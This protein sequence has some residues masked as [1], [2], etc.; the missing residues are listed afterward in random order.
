LQQL[1]NIVKSSKTTFQFF[2]RIV[3]L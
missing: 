1:K 3:I 2:K